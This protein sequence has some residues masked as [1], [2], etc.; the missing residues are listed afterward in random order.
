MKLTPYD[1]ITRGI[2]TLTHL[3]ETREEGSQSQNALFLSG[4]V[5]P[6]SCSISIYG[7]SLDRHSHTPIMKLSALTMIEFKT[8]EMRN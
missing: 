3:E 1:C 4:L 2:L 6:S 8:K 5:F 7:G